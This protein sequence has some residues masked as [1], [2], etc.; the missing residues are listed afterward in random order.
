MGQS[1]EI[2]HL[3]QFRDRVTTPIALLEM[4]FSSGTKWGGGSLSRE[5][6]CEQ[7]LRSKWVPWL[8]VTMRQDEAACYDKKVGT[9]GKKVNQCCKLEKSRLAV[10]H[11]EFAC[12]RILTK[13]GGP[14][15]EDEPS[16]EEEEYTRNLSRKP[17]IASQ[18]DFNRCPYFSGWMWA[19]RV[20]NP[21][22]G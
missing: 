3:G 18:N 14:D 9:G 13:K 11:L 10:S 19:K 12:I 1:E 20:V 15:I 7:V 16:R 5:E 2:F 8:D 6:Q 21:V 17:G 4:E 22:L